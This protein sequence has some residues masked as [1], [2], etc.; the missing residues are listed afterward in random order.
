MVKV[1]AVS[2]LHGDAQLS[3]RLVKK[4]LDNDV[5][6]VI[7]A[8]DLTIFDKPSPNLIKPFNDAGLKVLIIPGNHDSFS[9]LY[10]ITL[11]YDNVKSLHNAYYIKEGVG[12][13]GHHATSMGSIAASDSE[14]EK[15][16]TVNGEKLSSLTKKVMVVHEPPI[17]TKLDNIG[18]SIGN[19]GVRSVIENLRPDLV[20][21]GH[22][23]ERFGQE[24]VIGDTRIINAGR[25][26]VIPDL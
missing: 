23:H 10:D 25:N 19:Q 11:L 3:E 26:G 24:D 13:F 9:T 18:Y 7:I 21:C 4:A 6:L 2:D 12:F 17:N 22:V 8:G 20:I 15:L 5:K 1:L 14:I 16:L